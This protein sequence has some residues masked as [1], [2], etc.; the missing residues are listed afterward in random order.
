MFGTA[1]HNFKKCEYIRKF[2]QKCFWREEQIL[3]GVIY[4][5][6]DLFTL[7]LKLVWNQKLRMP[8]RIPNKFK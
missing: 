1:C 8:L 7:S 4:T 3:A 2:C 5:S 6:E